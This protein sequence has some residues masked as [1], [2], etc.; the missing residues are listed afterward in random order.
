MGGGNAT[1]HLL[2]PDGVYLNAVAFDDEWRDFTINDSRVA[3]L[4][5]LAATVVLA[6][7]AL[8]ARGRTPF[9]RHESR[10][11]WWT[12]PHGSTRR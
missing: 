11:T 6:G 7:V 3:A 5:G 9:R 1:L 4:A 10:I 8:R 12:S 2:S